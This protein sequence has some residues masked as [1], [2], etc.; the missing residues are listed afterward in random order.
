VS[1]SASGAALETKVALE[2]L[3][4]LK[5][6]IVDSAGATIDGDLYVKIT[7][8]AADD[9]T[10][11]DACTLRFTAVPPLVKAFVEEQLIEHEAA[12]SSNIAAL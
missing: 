6:R 12:P 1:L 10:V 7:A 8:R 3:T 9:E 11:G 4:N 5:I 2:P